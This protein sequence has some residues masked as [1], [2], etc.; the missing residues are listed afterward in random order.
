[1]IESYLVVEAATAKLGAAALAL[2]ALEGVRLHNNEG[3][4]LVIT[5]EAPT[6]ANMKALIGAIRALP[7]VTHVRVIHQRMR[8]AV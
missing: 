6:E 3:L 1:M 5:A 2:G 4:R 7:E 8:N